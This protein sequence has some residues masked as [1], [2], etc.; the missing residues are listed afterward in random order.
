MGGGGGGQ[1]SWGKRGAPKGD[2]MVS[3]KGGEKKNEV[4]D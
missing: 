3:G 4:G 2:Y 1:K